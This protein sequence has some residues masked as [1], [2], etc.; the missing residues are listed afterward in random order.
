M[1]ST[2]F[3]LA[4]LCPQLGVPVRLCGF[5]EDTKEHLRKNIGARKLNVK[6]ND[7]LLV[8]FYGTIRTIISVFGSVAQRTYT[9]PG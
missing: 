3:R 7:P 4:I 5:T 9:S 1:G 8:C 2:F 6:H